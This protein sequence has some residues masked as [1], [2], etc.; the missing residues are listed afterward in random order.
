MDSFTLHEFRRTWRARRK[1]DHSFIVN[2]SSK[3]LYTWLI[4]SALSLALGVSQSL[5]AQTRLP[6]LLTIGA[7][8]IFQIAI[9]IWFFVTPV[10]CSLGLMDGSLVVRVL[11]APLFQRYGQEAR[12]YVRFVAIEPAEIIGI[13]ALRSVVHYPTSI[14][15]DWVEVTDSLRL[16]LTRQAY[17]ELSSLV[18]QLDLDRRREGKLSL[19][20][21]WQLENN[22]LGIDWE[23]RSSPS[24]TETMERFRRAPVFKSI[25][26]TYQEKTI[27]LRDGSTM[28][29]ELLWSNIAE[30]CNIDREKIAAFVIMSLKGASAEDSLKLVREARAKNVRHEPGL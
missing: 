22:A 19:W 6:L 21:V 18:I 28:P 4:G 2:G 14:R 30:L 29:E 17:H 12:R 25:P 5:L 13:T 20:L 24:L 8:V 10:P 23:T 15:G 3:R 1:D 27:D 16:E 9:L 26:V 7:S 11:A